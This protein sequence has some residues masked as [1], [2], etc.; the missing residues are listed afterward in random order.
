VNEPTFDGATWKNSTF[1]SNLLAIYNQMRTA[2]PNRQIIMFTFHFLSL[3]IPGIV[4][5]YKNDIDWSHTSVGY[6][7]Y[8]STSSA[9]ITQIE[10]NYRVICTEWDYPGH[11][12]YIKEVDGYWLNAQT[13]EVLGHSWFDWRAWGDCNF[14][15]HETILFPDAHAKG[16]WWGAEPGN[17]APVVNAGADQT[18]R[19]PTDQV[20]LDGTVTDDGLPLGVSVSNTWSKVS[21]PG[22]V[23]FGNA[24]AV[25]TTATF[26]AAGVYVLRLTASD[27]L[28]SASDDVQITVYAD[29]PPP[30]FTS[31]GLVL[32]LDAA[33]PNGDE[34][35]PVNGTAIQTWYDKSGAA[36]HATQG[37]S[38]ARPV[39]RT[40]VVLGRPVI[41]FD[42]ND[43]KLDTPLIRGTQGG[44][45]CFAVSVSD[46]ASGD[47][48]QRIVSGWDSSTSDDFMAPG[49]TIF[50]PSSSGVPQ[51][52]PT[53]VFFFS[54]GSGR[55]IPAIRLGDNGKE[56]QNQSLEGDICEVL[57]YDR[58]LTGADLASVTNYLVAKWIS[59]PPPPG[60]SPYGGSARSLP[61]QIEAEHYDNGGEGIAY[62]DADQTNNGGATLRNDGVDIKDAGGGNYVIGWNQPG[63][64]REYTAN[65]SNRRYR[66]SARVST[67]NT[68]VQ[69]RVLLGDGSAGS[70]FVVLG[71]MD[72]PNTGSYDTF[73]E[74]VLDGVTVTNGGSG[75]VLR[76]ENLGN[77]FD[78]DWIKFDVASNEPPVISIAAWSN[79]TGMIELSWT[80]VSG[81]TY[82]VYKSTNLLE[83]WPAQPLTNNITGDGATKVFSEPTNSA[84]CSF[85]RLKAL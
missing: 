80:S 59:P 27:T 35:L 26:G 51:A 31:T 76:L 13:L 2:A 10:P 54:G 23:T 16:Y 72:I 15:L 60:Q 14:D 29:T 75:R 63:E 68:G 56:G 57:V 50:R 47:G 24:A 79:Q 66:I 33:D 6:H 39:F 3:D 74:G 11:A 84:P 19:L 83:E 48:W 46:Q 25:D 1:K 18:I 69:Q 28:L 7:M 71:T 45:H 8:G 30:P 61:G 77:Y 22:T 37:T 5:L 40:N 17:Q 34:S 9:K 53:T 12:D 58:E 82:A 67:D 43:D 62:H 20:A 36:R 49:W 73:Q 85:Y 42:G 55:T 70:N 64:W 78:I 81:T 38:G 65:I 41:R 21:G 4:D 44:V 52:Y 32:W